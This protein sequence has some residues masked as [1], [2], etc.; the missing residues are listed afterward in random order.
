MHKSK[1][2]HFIKAKAKELGFEEVGIAKAEFLDEEAPRL[3]Q[4]LFQN[5]HG[6]MNYMNNHFDMRLNPTLL[7]PDAKSVISLS[8]NYFTDITQ[9]TESYKISKY[10]YG[11]DY[12]KIIKKKL[13]LLLEAIQTEIGE[14]SGRAFVDSAPVLE[15]AWARKAGIAWQGKNAMML[16][17][18][19]GSFYFL[20]EL[21]IDLELDYDFPVKDYC[22]TCTKCIAACPT[23]AII[24]PYQVDGSKCISYFTIELKNEIP[25]AMKGKLD[26][27][28]FGCDICQNVCPINA[29]AKNHHEEAFKPSS[30]WLAYSKKDW[31]EITEDI[32]NKVFEGSPLKRTK[33]SGIK[34][35]I[36]FMQTKV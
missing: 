17:K 15:R 5:M 25:L 1:W 14:V 36:A 4:W 21:I 8:Y 34:R 7:V 19:K 9:H 26:D 6:E 12:H 16:T 20:A 28:I 33:F 29:R 13:N 10:A 32:F 23:E 18:T 3:E 22:G 27:W 30:E 2:S 35:N 11:K 24:A 31:Q